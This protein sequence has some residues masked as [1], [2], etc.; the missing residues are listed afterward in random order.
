M[1]ARRV[2]L[3]GARGHTGRE[4]LRLIG[5]RDDLDLV[6][7]SSRE[8]A[9]RPVAEMAPEIT[10]GLD[11]EALSPDDVAARK[12][13]AVILALPNGAAAPFV[14]AI[15][16]DCVIVDLSADYRFDEA[17]TYG[18]PEIYGRDSLIGA[19]RIAN[20]GCYATAGQLA[21][22]PLRGQLD[23]DVHVFGVSGYSGAGTT[24]SRKN[25]PEAL[26]DNL[27]PYALSGHLHEQ[28][29]ARHAG[30]TVRFTPH[31]A[32]FFR[33]IVATTHLTLKTAMSADA[34]RALYEQ[35]YAG[36]A[37]IR[38]I[39]D[40]PEVRDGARQP[41]AVVGGFA[42]GADGHRLVVVSALDNLLKGAA[43]QAMQNLTLALGLPEGSYRPSPL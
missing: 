4:L 19:R 23:G 17:W 12:V 42:V 10:N 1:S 16:D 32:A 37:L 34:V 43:V 18:L 31:V 8:W 24:P 6:F 29:M 22:A 3:V 15:A 7:A 27:M 20:P 14:A 40:I 39:A 38:V 2:G 21:I 26:A 9:G 41:G 5:E 28:E 30:E 25:D 35:A 33:G 13:D 11:F 36:E